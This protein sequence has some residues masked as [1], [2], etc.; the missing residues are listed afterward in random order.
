MRWA[1]I[2]AVSGT[3]VGCAL[4]VWTCVLQSLPANVIVG[5]NG[6]YAL[7]ILVN[8]ATWGLL[9]LLL[10]LAL[11]GLAGLLLGKPKPKEPSGDSPLKR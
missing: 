9:G 4:A 2:G 11:G 8:L 6:G 7:V 5:F 3:A 1:A 10:G